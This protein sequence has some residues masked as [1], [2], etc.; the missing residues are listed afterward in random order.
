MYLKNNRYG[1]MISKY[2]RYVDIGDALH[3]KMT[4]KSIY[5]SYMNKFLRKV[6][7]EKPCTSSL[8]NMSH[9]LKN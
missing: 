9:R 3:L 1:H 6:L 5:V 7:F 8:C 4:L 2:S